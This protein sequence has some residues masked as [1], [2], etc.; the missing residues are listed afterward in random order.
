MRTALHTVPGGV[1]MI[2]YYDSSKVRLDRAMM[3]PGMMDGS[4]RAETKVVVLQCHYHI[5]DTVSYMKYE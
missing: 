3:T 4:T 5:Y 1:E 2:Q